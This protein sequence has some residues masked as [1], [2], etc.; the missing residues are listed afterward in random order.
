[1]KKSYR[2]PRAWKLLS[3]TFEI[4]FNFTPYVFKSVWYMYVV[5]KKITDAM[6]NK[7]TISLL[8]RLLYSLEACGKIVFQCRFIL[9]AYQRRLTAPV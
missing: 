9:I 5:K 4:Q 7:K 8:S 6:P 1:M 3:E 2:L